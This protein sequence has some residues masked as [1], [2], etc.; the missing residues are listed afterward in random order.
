[1]AKRQCPFCKESVNAS[2]TICKHCKSDL[3]PLP[4]KKWHQ[5]GLGQLV[6]LVVVVF[7]IGIIASMVGSKNEMPILPKE[8]KSAAINKTT[9]YD[10]KDREAVDVVK[11]CLVPGAQKDVFR[12]VTFYLDTAKSMGS[13]IE[14]E[15]WAGFQVSGPIYEVFVAWKAN[16]ESKKARWDVDFEKNTI[17]IKNQEAFIFSGKNDFL[18]FKPT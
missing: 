9:K 15:G 14:F 2:A 1:M 17:K 16:N 10:N 18:T 3:P 4:K 6:G 5:T 7:I 13:F 8:N 11:Y 12:M